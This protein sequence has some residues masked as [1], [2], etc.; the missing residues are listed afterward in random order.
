VS[1]WHNEEVRAALDKAAR[2]RDAYRVIPVL[3]PRVVEEALTDFL[4]RHTWV[5][6]RLGMD[7]A[8]AF[9]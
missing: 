3:L 5:D 9:A 1:P 6:F 2:F 4:A 7:D 8:D